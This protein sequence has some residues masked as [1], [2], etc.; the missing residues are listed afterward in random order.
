M[1]VVFEIKDKTGRKIRL[2]KERWNHIKQRHQ[3]VADFEEI[4]L[5][6]KNPLKTVDDEENIMIYYKYFKN[7]KEHAKYLK[8]IVKY[9]NGEG[10]VITS[11]FVKN[12]L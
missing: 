3:N 4:E 6:I 12:M 9:L 7:R 10:Y 1:D 11:Y 8:V 5:V 2:S